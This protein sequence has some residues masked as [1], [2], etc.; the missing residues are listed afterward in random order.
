MRTVTGGL[1]AGRGIDATSELQ[2]PLHYV[3]PCHALQ[4]PL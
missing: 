2:V 4:I 3:Q 1:L